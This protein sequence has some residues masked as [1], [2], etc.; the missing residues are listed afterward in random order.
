MTSRPWHVRSQPDLSSFDV[1]TSY[2]PLIASLLWHRGVRSLDEASAFFRPDFSLHLHDPWSFRQMGTAIDRIIQAISTGEKIM[3]SGDYDADGVT[4]TA[5]LVETLQ[6]LGGTVEW[7]V[8][9]R[10]RDGYGLRMETI[11]Q[12]KTQGI[13]LLITVDCGT[14]NVAEIQRANELGIDVIV[15]DHHQRPAELP[16]ALAIINPVFPEEKYPFRG[17]SSAGVVFTVIRALLQKTNYGASLDR[18]LKEGWEKWLLDLVA[19]STVAD[20]MPLHGENR[21]LVHFGVKVLQRTRRPGLQALLATSGISPEDI[22][23][24]TLG[25]QLGPR[26]NAAGRLKHASLAVKLLLTADVAEAERLAQELQQLNTDRKQLTE[27]ACREAKQHIAEMPDQLGYAVFAPHWSPGILGLVAGRVAES[28]GRPVFVMT[29][30]GDQVVGSGRSGSGIDIMTVMNAGKEWFTKYGGHSGACGFTLR[31]DADPKA[32][33]AWVADYLATAEPGDPEP[34]LLDAEVLL[35]DIHPEILD[36][37]DTLSPFGVG[38]QRPS[39][40]VRDVQVD[41]IRCVGADQQ[42]LRLRVQ[43]N[44]QRGTMIGFRLAEKQSLVPSSRR[45]DVAVEPTWNEWNGRKEIQWRFVDLR[46][47]V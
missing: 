10:F 11:E 26:L 40:L 35:T 47:A 15:C 21:T 16:P 9:D 27:E 46:P 19:I 32:F 4:S 24:V 33:G 29:Q 13:D 30:N 44:G 28:I 41:E 34:L 3:I 42:H 12:F 20:M 8:P 38:A 5:M 39:F 7:F 36:M 14:T 23:E 2:P 43:Q 37:I 18:P 17:H 25:F 31:P 1:A 6:V 22:S 45:I